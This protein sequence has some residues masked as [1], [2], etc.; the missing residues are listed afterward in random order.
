MLPGGHRLLF[1]IET[2]NPS[3]CFDYETPL[4]TSSPSGGTRPWSHALR[5]EGRVLGHILSVRRDASLV[6]CSPS[7]GTRPW[8]HPL[9]Q[10]G[11][12]LGH[13]LSVRRD[14]PLVT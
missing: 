9:R 11:R 6:T 8:S 5:Q 7:G 3:E 2:T 13:I 12:A 10:E 1:Y 14:A 4:V